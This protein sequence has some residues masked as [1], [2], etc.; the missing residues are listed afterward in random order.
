MVL[1]T[2]RHA[3]DPISVLQQKLGQI[4]PILTGD[5]GDERGRHQ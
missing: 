1:L 4:E 2:A 3:N 5:P